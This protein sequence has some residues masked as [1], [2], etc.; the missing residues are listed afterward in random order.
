MWFANRTSKCSLQERPLIGL[1]CI[2]SSPQAC[3]KLAAMVFQSFKDFGR[4]ATTSLS[5]SKSCRARHLNIGF[6]KYKMQL[7]LF[8][9]LATSVNHRLCF[10]F[11]MF[12]SVQAR[13]K[14]AKDIVNTN[15]QTTQS[16]TNLFP[17]IDIIRSENRYLVVGF[18]IR[19][20]MRNKIIKILRRFSIFLL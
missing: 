5:R 6:K 15:F 9:F 8:I 18:F 20:F 13:I 19:Y 3:C 10:I 17:I 7:H 4:T 12:G 11:Y 16:H 14:I 1:L 2:S